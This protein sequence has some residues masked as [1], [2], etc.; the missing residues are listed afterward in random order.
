MAQRVCPEC[1]HLEGEYTFFCTECG[2]KTVESEASEP[3]KMRPSTGVHTS[4][5]ETKQQSSLAKEQPE[6]ELYH[7]QDVQEPFVQKSEPEVSKPDSQDKHEDISKSTDKSILPPIPAVYKR[8]SIVGIVVGTIVLIV[9]VAGLLIKKPWGA[10]A[11]IGNK[12]NS[13]KIEQTVSSDIPEGKNAEES[14][15]QAVETE[16]ELSTASAEENSNSYLTKK[17]LVDD[18]NLFS[19]EE[20]SSLQALIEQRSSENNM[21]IVIL[22]VNTTNG[23]YM[24]DFADDY[25]DYNGYGV[26]ERN[27]GLI[28][29][30]AM[31]DREWGISTTGSAIDL[32][33]DAEQDEIATAFIS[34]YQEAGAYSAMLGI[35]NDFGNALGGSNVGSVQE[36]P[37]DDI[38]A[39]SE[40]TLIREKYNE[41]VGLIQGNGCS[42]VD[43]NKDVI[44]Y[45]SDGVKAIYVKNGYDDYGYSRKYYYD[46]G[47]LIFAYFESNDAHRLYFK[48][49]RLFRWRYSQ[50]AADAQNAINHD[51]DNAEGYDTLEIFA[52]KEA[53]SLHA[54]ASIDV[55]D[56]PIGTAVVNAPDGGVN[57]RSG[58]GT[59]YEILVNMIPDGTEMKIYQLENSSKGTQW[60]YV[61]YNSTEGWIALSQVDYN[62]MN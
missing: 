17:L 20:K 35:I 57:L 45:I 18:A 43:I 54:K 13:V 24:Q 10:K 61:K 28:F 11:N 56:N 34:T 42:E 22:T 6:V 55:S 38:D 62:A 53:Y 30:L 52:I 60:G 9:L 14:T 5:V 41:I 40:V 46:N 26:G 51:S 15:G 8:S 29:V 32:L 33:T 1:G 2:A 47:K 25:Y 31:D 27:D 12:N 49:D 3:A 7:D 16:E 36:Q 59:E 23:K 21:D 4:H 19:D 39:E 44:G 50:N 58:P 37:I 48:N